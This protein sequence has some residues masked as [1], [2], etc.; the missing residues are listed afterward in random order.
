MS[1]IIKEYYSVVRG[2]VPDYLLDKKIED[3]S[4]NPDIEEEFEY[5]IKNH[6]YK[7]ENCV[8]I[9][10]YTAEGIASLSKYIDGEGAFVMLI[11]LR[12]NPEA[13]IR[14]IKAGFKYL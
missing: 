13:A 1:E 8:E 10:G 7:K 5:W 3:F 9:E 2:S 12:K 4:D 6:E 14:K 11:Q